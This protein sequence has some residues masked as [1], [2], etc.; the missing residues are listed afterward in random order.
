MRDFLDERPLK[1]RRDRFGDTNYGRVVVT[2]IA[3]FLLSVILIVLD[4]QGVVS[5][6]RLTIREQLQ[7]VISW[8][9]DRRMA[10]E[11]W[12][13][14]P[15]DVATLQTRVAE[16][17]AENAQL[18]HD[19]LR[20]EQAQVENI[21]LRQQLAMTQAHPW[22]VL[23]AE[24]MVRAPDAAR[25]VMTIARGANDGVQTGMAVIGQ[26]PGNPPALIGVVETVGPHTAE[27]LLITDISSQLSVRVLQPDGAPLGLLQGQWQRGSRLRVE[28]IDRGT[29]L[30]VG[31]HVVTAGLSGALDLPLDLSAMPAAVPI[32]FIEA[33][34][35]E[36]QRQIGDIRPFADPDQV[37]YVWVILS[38]DE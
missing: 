12:W 34:R 9:T 2:A 24:V 25:R 1:L 8:L 17:E 26:Q 4:R 21:F 18:R 23:G 36:G 14:T 35:Q 13:A 38:Q 6:I 15:R 5:P 32:G 27:V 16:L 10:F 31:E 7:P 29:T 37:R 22:R 30:R 19:V 28:L 3:L 20:L 11:A 33:V